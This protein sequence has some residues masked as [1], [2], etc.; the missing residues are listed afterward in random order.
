MGSRQ[1]QK[2]FPVL[3]LLVAA[4]LW[5]VSWYPLRLLDEA[6]FSGLWISVIIY[7]APMIIG[8][9]VCFRVLPAI[10]RHPWLL[11]IVALGNGWC[12]VSF[13]VAVLDG[14]VMRVLLL[15]YLSPL[16]TTVLGWVFLGE[17]LSRLSLVTLVIAM[18]GAIVMLWNPSIGAPWPTNAADWLAI[19][20]GMAFSLANVSL[21][22]LQD[23]SLRIK[24]VTSWTGVTII[25]LLW[26]AAIDHPLPSVAGEAW[27]WVTLLGPIVVLVM[28]FSVFY[29]V[30]N[31]PVYRS[32]IILLFELVVGAISSQ[33][34]THE[35]ITTR[36]WVGGS[37]IVL[38]AYLSARAMMSEFRV[39]QES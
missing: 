3:S 31:L 5:G 28:T 26:I 10:K 22:K 27:L 17:H 36:E 12:N 15:F 4:V 9:I 23:I 37:L 39:G 2:L 7:G 19:S 1:S 16:W 30:T 13:I 32:A 11:L 33:L 21:R 25:A 8:L 35:V 20:S 24:T 18:V 6:G 38:A 34:L 14:E 29:G